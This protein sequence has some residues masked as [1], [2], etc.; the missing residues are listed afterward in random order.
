[1]MDGR[2]GTSAGVPERS[3]TPSLNLVQA[4]VPLPVRASLVKNL[5]AQKTQ[6]EVWV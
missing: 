1:M 2:I 3:T 6:T 5:W 4:G